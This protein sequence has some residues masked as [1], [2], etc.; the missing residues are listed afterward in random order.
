MN[1]THEVLK[2]GK[3]FCYYIADTRCVYSLTGELVN[4]NWTPNRRSTVFTL[5]EIDYCL[6]NE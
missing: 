2:Y 5:R 1:Y 4:S 3:L 6:E